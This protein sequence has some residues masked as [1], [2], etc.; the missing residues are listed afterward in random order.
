MLGRDFNSRGMETCRGSIPPPRRFCAQPL[1]P[2]P[3]HPP[4]PVHRR[5]PMP[6]RREPLIG[7]R[8]IAP[9]RFEP[10]IPGSVGR[11]FIHWA[12]GPDVSYT[13]CAPLAQSFDGGTEV[14]VARSAAHQQRSDTARRMLQPGSPRRRSLRKVAKHSSHQP[15]QKIERS[16]ARI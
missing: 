3:A 15:A 1:V 11:C 5:D 7:P 16:L 14:S 12:T 2:P 10:A 8:K 6:R 13:H 9:A 4:Y